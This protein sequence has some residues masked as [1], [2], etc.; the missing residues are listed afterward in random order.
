MTDD[1][2]KVVEDSARGGFFLISGSLSATVISAVTSILIGRLLG[3]ELYGQFYLSLVIPQML[4]I[5]S[6]LGIAAGVTKF[7][8]SLRA[9]GKHY[10]AAKIIKNAIL[11]RALIALIFFLL[12]FTLAD[13]LASVLL[14]R[15]DLGFYVRLTSISIAFNMILTIANSA[16]LGLDKTHNAALITNIQAISEAIISIGL[17]AVGLSITGAVLG[18]VASYAVT[19][20]VGLSMLLLI[21]HRYLREKKTPADDFSFPQ[22]FKTLMRY[23]IPLY[24]SGILAGFIYQYQNFILAIFTTNSDIGNLRVAA[25]LITI[26]TVFSAPITTTLFPAFSKLNSSKNAELTTF[27]KFANKYV[28]LLIVPIATLLIIFSKEIVE[29]TYGSK[30]QTAAL[31]LSINCLL[32]FL[33]G[34]G[35]LTLTSLFNGLGETRITFKINLIIFL[36][37]LPLSPLLAKAYGVPGVISA[38]ISA[39]TAGTCYGIYTAKRK[40]KIKIEPNSI[41]KIYIIGVASTVPSILLLQISTLPQLIKIISGGLIYLFTYTTLAPLTKIVNKSELEIATQIVQKIKPFATII[42]PF[43]IYQ[44][45]ILNHQKSK[46]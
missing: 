3:P 40:F 43:L 17:V 39:N 18:Y 24:T 31:F 12:N 44:E 23:G 11:L 36:T 20:I 8:A 25:N 37:L 35:Y 5:F 22:T 30:Y 15:P 19:S 1:L 21:L 13:Y 42:K 32:Y 7:A 29:I 34:L 16:F 4:L 46:T 2:T 27:F 6:D 14:R 45:K 9:E 28:T 26:I 33:V 10:Q 41:I 38:L